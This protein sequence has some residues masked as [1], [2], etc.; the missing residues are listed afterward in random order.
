MTTIPIADIDDFLLHRW[1]E[2]SGATWEGLRIQKY[3]ELP[4]GWWIVLL[5]NGA[6]LDFSPEEPIKLIDREEQG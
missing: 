4:S 3:G 1:R 2:Y 6:I 5:E